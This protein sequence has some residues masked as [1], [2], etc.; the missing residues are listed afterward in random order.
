MSDEQEHLKKRGYDLSL[1]ELAYLYDLAAGR[2]AMPDAFL[3]YWDP[4]RLY[5]LGLVETRSDGL[6]YLTEQ[7]ARYVPLNRP[8]V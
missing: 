5:D 8:A 4:D 6:D 2:V 3:A 7:G 1:T